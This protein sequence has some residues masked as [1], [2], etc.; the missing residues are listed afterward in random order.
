MSADRQGSRSSNYFGEQKRASGVI[1]EGRKEEADAVILN[2]P[3]KSIL[4]LIP[5]EHILRSFAETLAISLVQ[6]L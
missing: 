4:R 3:A 5:K 6:M 1:V 2:S